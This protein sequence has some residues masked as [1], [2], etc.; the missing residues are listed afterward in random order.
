MLG[1][2][3]MTTGGH[4]DV[5]PLPSMEM[6]VDQTLKSVVLLQCCLLKYN[7]VILHCLNVRQTAEKST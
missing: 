1:F 6:E 2:L 5:I 4:T 7:T 3:A